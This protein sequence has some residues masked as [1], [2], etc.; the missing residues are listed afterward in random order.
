[1]AL[2]SLSLCA[3]VGGIDLGLERLGAARTVCY[4]EREAFPAACLVAAM[5]EGRLAQAPIWSDLR[6]FDARAWRGSVDLVVGGYPCQPFSAAGRRLG[7]A[8]PR[9]LWPEVL[10]IYRESGARYLF[11]ENVAGHLSL[12]FA[13][14]LAD[15]A[16]VGADVEW[17]LFRASDVGAPHR[18][19]RL[20]F[21]ADAHKPIGCELERSGQLQGAQRNDAFSGESLADAGHAGRRTDDAGR[22]HADGIDSERAQGA[23]RVGERGEDVAHAGRGSVERRRAT[24]DVDGA[25]RCGEGEGQQR[26]RDR[27]SARDGGEALA[28]RDRD[29]LGLG[30]QLDGE[31]RRAGEGARGRHAHGCG[32]DVEHANGAGEDVALASRIGSP[33]GLSGPHARQE[34][35]AGELD[36]HR[37][38]L[39]FPPGPDDR[40]GWAEWIAAGGPQPCVRRGADGLSVRVGQLRALGN[41]VVPQVAALAFSELWARLHGDE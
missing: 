10:R 1:M 27:N 36:D 9:H 41:A 26:E 19:E 6:T 35:V 34:G 17:G 18:R 33:S 22:I 16:E 13:D 20:F 21:L 29:G 38:Q 3:G 40:E 31:S 8:D 15:L 23:G 30:V 11:C 14:V 39:G 4:V 28:D 37:S 12:G 32:E 2:R 5:Q 24:G 7:A 25:A